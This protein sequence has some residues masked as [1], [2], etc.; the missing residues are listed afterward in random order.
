MI[1]SENYH[2]ISGPQYRP[3]KYGGT[4]NLGKPPRRCCVAIC[5]LFSTPDLGILGKTQ[6]S[7]DSSN[8]DPRSI[9]PLPLIGIIIEVL[10]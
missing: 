7:A 9:N 6:L 10:I 4:P 8:V 1:V 2:N 3:S 5:Q